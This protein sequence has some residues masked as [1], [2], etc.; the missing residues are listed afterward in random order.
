MKSIAVAGTLD[1]KGDE[2]RFIK[3]LLDG[4]GQQPFIIDIGIQGE[5]ALEADA[6]RDAV[7]AAAG[8]N[9]QDI[10]ALNDEGC[11]LAEMGAAFGAFLSKLYSEEKIGGV[12]ALGG[13]RGT[14]IALHALE[15]LPLGFPKALVTSSL[16]Q[17]DIKKDVLL[18]PSLCAM[19]GLNRL[20][21]QLLTSA[22]GAL[23]GM[24]PT[25]DIEQPDK[26]LVTISMNHKVRPTALHLRDLLVK[27]GYE[28]L[29]FDTSARQGKAMEQ[30]IRDETV[31]VS[32]ELA[33]NDLGYELLTGTLNGRLEAAGEKGVSQIV[34]PGCTDF[35][36]FSADQAVPDKYRGLPNREEVHGRVVRTGKAE[37]SDIGKIMAAKLNAAHGKVQLLIPSRGFSGWDVDGDTFRDPAADSEFIKTLW[38]EAG[39]RVK[40]VDVDMH[41][42]DTAFAE[43]LYA[44]FQT[45]IKEG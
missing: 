14:K 13:R 4:K 40:V 27:D 24:T 8:K 16:E 36:N 37:M 33:I 12:L 42:N 35:V 5:S 15:Q 39:T 3:E 26:K 21:R 30:F 20:S 38:H 9:L 31:F 29:L 28:V 32:I 6:T 22:V 1:T 41:I 17:P 11:A 18:F 19:T 2:V 44:W 7:L 23:M 34:T 25:T 10:R 43:T 45:T